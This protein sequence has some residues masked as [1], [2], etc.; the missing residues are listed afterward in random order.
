[1]NLTV[2]ELRKLIAQ[3]PD[4]ALIYPNWAEGCLPNDNEPGVEIVGIISGWDVQARKDFLSVEV[5]LFYPDD[6]LRFSINYVHRDCPKQPG[7]EWSD[8]WDSVC[9]GQCPACGVKDIEPLTWEDLG[10]GDADGAK[11]PLSA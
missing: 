10:E 9:N 4:E 1:M 5:R 2:G 8:T 3:L 7:I 11:T 6:L